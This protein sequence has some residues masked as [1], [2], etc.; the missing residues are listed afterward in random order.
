[1]RRGGCE[2]DCGEILLRRLLLLLLEEKAL[3]VTS[4]PVCTPL[5]SDSSQRGWNRGN[6][7]LSRWCTRMSLL[8]LYWFYQRIVDLISVLKL[9]SMPFCLNCLSKAKLCSHSLEVKSL[10]WCLGVAQWKN[11]N[12]NNKY[13]CVFKVSAAS[14]I[15][16]FSSEENQMSAGSTRTAIRKSRSRCQANSSSMLISPG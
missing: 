3:L 11:N 12:N 4:A 10:L 13:R 8:N 15:L 9:H 7:T 6:R 5:I 2:R 14:L 16:T 1:M